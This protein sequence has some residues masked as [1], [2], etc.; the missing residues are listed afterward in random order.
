MSSR[1]EFIG[2]AI[3]VGSLVLG[4]R[5]GNG[6]AR[7][8]IGTSLGPQTAKT[9]TGSK[10]VAT[11]HPL[12]SKAAMTMYRDGGNAVD[13]AVAAA[14]V[15][16][17]V[18]GHNSGIGGGCLILI[19]S[20]SGTVHA[21]DGREK[22]PSAASPSLYLRD[23]KPSVE[24]SQTGPL[25]VG[26]PSQVAALHQ[27]HSQ[28]GRLAWSSLFEPAIE[29]ANDGYE[30]GSATHNAIT[31]EFKDLM[32][33]EA[34]KMLLGT[35]AGK[36]IAL[37]EIL[38][39]PDLAKTLV[40][41]AK[42]GPDWFY[43]GD[44]ASRCAS[45][46]KWLGG[47]LT[48]NDFQN[49]Q[50]VERKHLETK[51]RSFRIL[52]FPPP[53]S[54]GIH[55]AQMLHI[56]QNFDV[57]TI[58]RD[59]PA[60]FYHLMAEAMKLAFADRAHWLG[61]S[62]FVS[63]P[64]FLTDP[65][66]AA[67]L[68]KKIRLDKANLVAGHGTSPAA[69]DAKKHTTHLTACDAAGN[70]VAITA[71]VNTTWGSKVMV[72]GTGV[73]LNNQMD[74]FSIAPGVPNAFGLVGSEANAV[75]PNKR[76]LSSMSPTIVLQE[77]GSP[78]MTCGAAG[79]PKIINATLQNIVRCIDLDESIDTAIASA[80]V[81]QQWRPDLLYAEKGLGGARISAASEGKEIGSAIE[82]HGSIVMQ[83]ESLGH[84]IRESSSLAIAQGV[85]STA[86][87]LLAVSDP[88]TAGAAMAR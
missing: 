21:I 11:V 47:V 10:V 43:R 45:Y 1:R 37:G 59:S 58:Y 57:A 20:A 62:D 34:S 78:F 25:A 4:L 13:A 23:G 3:A 70:W 33:Y 72:P 69:N 83:L 16:G 54:G 46:L 60:T 30:I 32:K 36:P 73:M 61:D 63:V 64:G 80:R 52:G 55:I 40:Q 18:D 2:S 17:V 49:Y 67:D 86:T 26:V 56:L 77:D 65:N 35:A 42:N 5:S 66:Y 51:Y 85:Q 15:L 68:S 9:A 24:L 12:A 8:R 84:T 38:R 87:G 22:A 14:L 88:R 75:A 76:P 48:K 81:H 19:R 41:I 28:L 50:A 6:F 27:A 82:K 53:S 7:D 79:G 31:A 44:F 39:Q 29:I 71:T 74:D